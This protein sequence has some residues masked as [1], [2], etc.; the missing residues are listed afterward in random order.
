MQFV[1]FLQYPIWRRK[2]FFCKILFLKSVNLNLKTFVSGNEV[3]LNVV[4][5][6]YLLQ[7]EHQLI[8]I[9]KNDLERMMMGIH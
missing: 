4:L 8:S 7:Y 5:E 9:R 1:F 6:I 3:F 2:P